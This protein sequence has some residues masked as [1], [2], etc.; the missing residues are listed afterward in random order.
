MLLWAVSA[1]PIQLYFEPCG[2]KEEVDH[3]SSREERYSQFSLHLPREKE[4][5]RLEYNEASF[6]QGRT[7]SLML[8][9]T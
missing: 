3:D 5:H 1:Q 9:M 4:G 8:P 6:I 2:E 7:L